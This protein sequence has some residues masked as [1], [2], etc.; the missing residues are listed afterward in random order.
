MYHHIV[1]LFWVVV[2]STGPA[3]R[4]PCYQKR[5][6]DVSRSLLAIFLVNL[7]GVIFFEVIQ[8]VRSDHVI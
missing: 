3:L 4:I 7:Y 2:V 1:F 5:D 8:R 6:H